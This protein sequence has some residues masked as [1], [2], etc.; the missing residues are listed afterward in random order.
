MMNSQFEG[1]LDG[2][3]VLD[4]TRDLAGPYASMILAELGA[5][6][7]EIEH[8]ETG[9]ETRLWPPFTNGVSGYFGTIN[10]S[11]RSLALNYKT[12][13]GMDAVY[14]L[15]READIVMQSFTPGVADR[16]GLGYE[17][18]RTLNPRIIYL[19]I[20]GFGQD[21]PWSKKRGYDPILQAASGFMSVTGE[22]GRTP[23]KSMIP[24]ADV[25]TGIYSVS[26]VLAALYRQART[27]KGQSIDMSMFDVNVGM[28][29]VVGTRYLLT[30]EVPERQGTENPQRV[31]SAAFECSDGVYLQ[32]VP[33]QRQWTDFCDMLD[34]PD[35]ADHE[36]YASPLDRVRN[37]DTL[38]PLL[39][40][41]FLTRTS[42]EWAELL[43][44]NRI[45][46]SPIY[47]LNEVFSLEHTK[48]R[49]IATSYHVEGIGEVPAIALPFKL[50][51]TP[52]R[53]YSAPP[54]LGEHTEEILREIGRTD[55]QIEEMKASGAVR[56]LEEQSV[57]A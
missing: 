52:S 51:E 7:I 40:E 19:S 2:V 20:S 16:L 35:L 45:A 43:E 3:K 50:S 56:G 38:Y 15:V 27:G 48:A 39:R 57:R 5:Q 49:G 23:V 22:K 36:L 17:K 28:T 32:L 53:I 31:P 10:R 14:D 1:A 46:H 30:G 41:I 25:S 6:V 4:L 12:Q 13:E 55:E 11:K 8:P 47:R 29:T 21:G 54:R 34:R 44:A 9:D 42:E 37:Q 18:L 24:V 33:N 26:A